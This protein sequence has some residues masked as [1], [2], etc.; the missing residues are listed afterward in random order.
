ML[1]F[2]DIS[3]KLAPFDRLGSGQFGVGK[4]DPDSD[5]FS[6]HYF[7]SPNNVVY[8]NLFECRLT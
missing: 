7:L 3:N 1:L 4:W 8:L 5:Y 2:P 6:S